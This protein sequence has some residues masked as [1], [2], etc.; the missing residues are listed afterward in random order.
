[1]IVFRYLAETE[2]RDILQKNTSN[3]GGNFLRTNSNSFKYREDEKYIHFF[4]K[5]TD[6]EHI[7]KVHNKDSL[8]TCFY[9]CAF[10]IPIV[11]LILSAGKGYYE[12]SGYDT[13]YT[14]AREFAI[15]VTNFNPKWLVGY[16]KDDTSQS[17]DASTFESKI[18]SGFH[19]S[20]SG[21]EARK[22]NTQLK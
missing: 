17:F 14:T 2:L 15:P 6:I 21:K 5:A 19:D 7:R 8:N 16:I 4:K 20:L 22:F 12:T 10:D 9:Y 13:F 3:I 1:M 11:Q 18:K